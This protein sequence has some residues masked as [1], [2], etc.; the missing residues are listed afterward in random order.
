VAHEWGRKDEFIQ[1]MF[2]KSHSVHSRRFYEVALRKFGQFYAENGYRNKVS[3]PRVMKIEDHQLTLR[4][5]RN[6]L[7]LGLPNRRCS[8]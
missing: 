7:S 8:P 4:T 5:I 2:R 6:L 3:I 1:A